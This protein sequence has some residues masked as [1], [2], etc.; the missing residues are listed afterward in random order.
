MSKPRP[1]AKEIAAM[2]SNQ[3]AA[4]APT[5]APVQCHRRGEVAQRLGV[6]VRTIERWALFGGGPP[7]VVIG[8]VRLYPEAALADWIASRLVT[9][10]SDAAARGKIMA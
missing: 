2:R 4:T 10:T 3:T 6:S 1:A 7:F 9:S 5:P 8:G